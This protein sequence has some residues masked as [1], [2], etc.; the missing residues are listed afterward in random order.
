MKRPSQLMMN[1]KPSMYLQVP[2]ANIENDGGSP[3]PGNRGR[4]IREKFMKQ[5]PAS[6]FGMGMGVGGLNYPA[7]KH[8]LLQMQKYDDGLQSFMEDKMQGPLDDMQP[9]LPFMNRDYSSMR[10]GQGGLTYR[11]ISNVPAFPM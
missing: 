2:N 11:Q 7:N 1:S 9:S 5:Q 8:S 3:N 4:S 10:F 6:N